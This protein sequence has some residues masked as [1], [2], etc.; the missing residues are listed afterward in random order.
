MAQGLSWG[1]APEFW[2]GWGYRGATNMSVLLPLF[3]FSWRH[4]SF[5]LPQARL[6][7]KWMAPESIFDKV[8]TT[9]SD[10]WSFGVLLW[11]IFSLGKCGAGCGGGERWDPRPGVIAPGLRNRGLFLQQAVFLWQVVQELH[12]SPLP[13]ACAP[14]PPLPEATSAG[15]WALASDTGQGPACVYQA[16][17]GIATVPRCLS[18]WMNPPNPQFV[19]G[20]AAPAFKGQGASGGDWMLTHRCTY[21]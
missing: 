2:T 12:L 9:Q 13:P 14:T 18:P 5:R 16:V 3:P 20:K 19:N 7:L 6:P 15:W 11:E 8:Y 4:A 1:M 21:L 17:A 10:V